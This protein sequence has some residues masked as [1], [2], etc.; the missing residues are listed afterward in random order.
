MGIAAAGPCDSDGSPALGDVE[1]SPT[2]DPS[3]TFYVE[4]VNPTSVTLWQETNGIFVGGDV[5]RDFQ[6]GCLSD[7]S[8]QLDTLVV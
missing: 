2:N 6:G 8:A 4:E 3:L 7:G 5:T 1:V